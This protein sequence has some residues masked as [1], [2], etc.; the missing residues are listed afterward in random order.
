MNDSKKIT[1]NSNK[2]LEK[3]SIINQQISI[4]NKLVDRSSERL[5]KE[6]FEEA[7]I[8]HYKS[9]DYYRANELYEKAIELKPDFEQ[10]IDNYAQ[11]MR[12]NIKDYIKAID[13]YS[14]LIDINPKYEY[15]Y[16][17]RSRCKEYL[18]N[19]IG[20]IEDRI[21]YI[22]V[23]SIINSDDYVSIA[24]IKFKIFDFK[25]AIEDCYKAIEIDNKNSYAFTYLGQAKFNL[26]NYEDAIID[27]KTS[28]ELQ[29][30]EIKL[31]DYN[32]RFSYT[33]L[34]YY[35]KAKFELQEYKSALK[36]FL[37]CIEQYPKNHFIYE[38]I[39]KV[40]E[41]LNNFEDYKI[42]IDKFNLLN[43]AYLKIIE[44]DLL[45]K[46]NDENIK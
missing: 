42:N 14:K 13:L 7:V 5:A 20:A 25:G 10:A 27:F 9:K 46:K 44:K 41:K 43:E 2:N 12:L 28:I 37:K 30:E 33:T 35:G 40:Y 8:L 45:R 26:Q 1:I 16:Y 4:Y 23:N 36:I 19:Y 31:R 34:L 6:Y 29:I 11:N 38:L 15:A 17:R 39:A 32:Q 18:K 21:E 24:R 22:K 3:L